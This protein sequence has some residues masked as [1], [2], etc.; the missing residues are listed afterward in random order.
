MSV[1]GATRALPPAPELPRPRTLLVGTGFVTS[2]MLM[3]FGSLFGIYFSTRDRTIAAGEEWFPE[4]AISLVPGGM[5]MMS[6][7]MSVITVQW[8]VHAIRRDDRTHALVALL[9]TAVLG[10]ATINQ[11]VFYWKDMALPIDSNR[12]AL[13]MWVIT[14]T[15]TAMLAV[16]LVFLALM[17][18]R[19]FGGQYTSR[20]SDGVVAAAIFWYALVL[21]YFVIWYGIYISK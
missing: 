18:I 5:M 17:A 11:Q 3:L 20:Q 6:L 14:G 16:G 1:A 21:V 19:A 13:Q 4:G 15:F 12:A 9:V 8:A 2:A 7:A 10:A